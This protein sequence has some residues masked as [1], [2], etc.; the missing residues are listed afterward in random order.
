MSPP[1]FTFL[2]IVIFAFELVNF[3]QSELLPTTMGT[4][5]STVVNT[6]IE[7]TKILYQ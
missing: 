4:L 7:T 5:Y 3:K 1:T 6:G 2:D